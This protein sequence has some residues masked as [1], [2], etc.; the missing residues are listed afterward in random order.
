MKITRSSTIHSLILAAALSIGLG[1][2]SPVSAKEHSYIVDLNSKT[3]TALGSLGMGGTIAEGINDSGQV[4]GYSPTDT[5]WGLENHAFI[6]GPNGKGMTDIGNFG[7]INNSYAPGI[8]AT[9]QVVV[10]SLG[11]S[12]GV[13]TYSY[14]YI[15]GPNGVGMTD[16]GSLGGGGSS[17]KG[18]NDAGQ[19]VGM[20]LTGPGEQLAFITGPNGVGMTDLGSL[21]GGGSSANGIN[22]AGQVVG[23][24]NTDQLRQKEPG[25]GAGERHAFITG[26]HGVGMTDLGTLDGSYFSVANGI[27]DAGRVVG[28]S[29]T[30]V[31][32]EQ[33]AFITGP[34][35]V[36]MTDLGT[37]GG[38]ESIANGINEAGQVVGHSDTAA[39][40]QHAFITGP[41][42]VGMTDLNSLINVPGII[43][44]DVTAI[45]NHGQILAT[46]VMGVVPEPETYAMLLAGLGLLGFIA[47]CR[48]TA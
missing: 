46:G 22:D 11:F 18:I 41:N 21:G 29:T 33:H 7:G 48:K 34:N 47:R 10:N 38:S 45:N 40:V 32:D 17:A 13:G 14:A 3:A 16:L 6:T 4:V 2:V 42:G 12:P 28:N 36:G 19:V 39:G 25:E 9:G 27:N 23:Y 44:T 5:I 31:W 30:A 26:P 15:S 24:S 37:L 1:F 8:N 43:L 20:S 35:G